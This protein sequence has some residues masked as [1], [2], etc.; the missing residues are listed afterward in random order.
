MG[1]N[2]CETREPCACWCPF[3]GHGNIAG[4]C[5]LVNNKVYNKLVAGCESGEL[6]AIERAQWCMSDNDLL[7][8]AANICDEMREGTQ[9]TA[10]AMLRRLIAVAAVGGYWANRCE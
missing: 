5:A 1:C 2:V 6:A 4:L 9:D 10:V 8:F 3:D 7:Y